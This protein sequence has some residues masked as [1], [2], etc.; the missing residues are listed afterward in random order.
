MELVGLSNEINLKLQRACALAEAFVKENEAGSCEET[1]INLLANEV[2]GVM[3]RNKCSWRYAVHR[4]PG[5]GKGC[6]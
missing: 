2:D 5:R 6:L 4:T 1:G 3:D